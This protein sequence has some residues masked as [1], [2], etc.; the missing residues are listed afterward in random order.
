MATFP[1]TFKRVAAYR[2]V[3]R[4]DQSQGVLF[5]KLKNGFDGLEPS[6]KLRL[7]LA[8][9]ESAIVWGKSLGDD[10]LFLHLVTYQKDAQIGLVPDNIDAPNAVITEA[11]PPPNFEFIKTQFY[12]FVQKFYL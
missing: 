10:R 4:V 9:Q 12:V 11:D 3:V 7:Q 6:K 8:G 2:Q 1:K 5:A